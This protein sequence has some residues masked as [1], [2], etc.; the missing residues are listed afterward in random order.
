MARTRTALALALLLLFAGCSGGAGTQE[1]G[2]GNDVSFGGEAGDGVAE[3]TVAAEATAQQTPAPRDASG[4]AGDVPAVRQNRQLI[5]T[6]EARVEVENF[7]QARSRLVSVVRANGGFVGSSTRELN[8]EG[9]RTWTTGRLVLRVPAENYSAVIAAVNE[10]GTVT[11][12]RQETRDVT[13]R[14][15]DLEARLENLRAERDQLRR[16]FRRA[17]ETEDVLAVQERL[18]DVQAEIERTEAQLKQLRRQVALSTITVRLAER[19]PERDEPEESA[20]FETPLTQAFAQSVDGV[21][22]TVRA[23]AVLFA[24]ALPYL[25]AFGLPLVGVAAGVRRYRGGDTPPENADPSTGPPN[26]T[27]RDEPATDESDDSGE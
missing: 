12:F 25:L 7:D 16:L 18:S 3:G 11:A 2:G 14:I 21:V 4:K 13:D 5:R 20:W 10:T 19:P 9:N 8:G 27:D 15:V 22:T 1:S 6:A 26:E 24:F 17:N 23:T